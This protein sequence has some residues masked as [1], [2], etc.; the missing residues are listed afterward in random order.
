MPA[1]LVTL[2]AA[3]ACMLFFAPILFGGRPPAGGDGLLQAAP[4]IEAPPHVWQPFSGLG[5]PAYADPNAMLFYPVA[6]LARA[7]PGAFEFFMVAPFFIASCALFALCWRLTRSVA[8]AAT[9]A[10]VFTLGGFLI[11]HFGHYNI[12]HPAAWSIV[13]FAALEEVRA[14]PRARWPCIV[15][16]LA[17]ALCALGGQPQI[18]AFALALGIAYAIAFARSA[19]EGAWHYGRRVA[20]ASGLGLALA[21]V[22]LIPE[23]RLAQAS[24]RRALGIDDLVLYSLPLPELP[25]QLLFPH[26]LDPQ[27]TAIAEFSDYAGVFGLLLALV[28]ATSAPRDGRVR[29]WCLIALLGAALSLGQ[30]LVQLTRHLPLYGL[31]RVPGRHAY[32]TTLALAVLASFGAATI[33]RKRL[34]LRAALGAI[35]GLAL[36]GVGAIWALHDGHS[37]T[38]DAMRAT[39]PHFASIDRSAVFVPVAIGIAG[40]LLVALGRFAPTAMLAFA[41]PA[42]ALLDLSSF[43]WYSYWNTS[44]AAVSPLEPTALARFLAPRLHG[45]R[46]A[47]LPGSAGGDLPPNLNVLWNVPLVENYSSLVLADSAAL[48]GTSGLT[49]RIADVDEAAFDLADVRYVAVPKMPPTELAAS[50]PIGETTLNCYIGPPASGAPAARVRLGYPVPIVADTIA[51]VTSLGNGYAIRDGV[52]VADLIVTFADGTVVRRSVRAGRDTAEFAYD[53]PDIRPIV[54][55]ARAHVFADVGAAGHLYIATIALGHRANVVSAEVRWRPGVGERAAMTV[56]ALSFVDGRSGRAYPVRT[57][58]WELYAEPSHWRP[59]PFD[60]DDVFENRGTL[61]RAWIA[62]R[63]LSA[64]PADAIAAIR[65]ARPFPYRTTAVVDRAPALGAAHAGDAV[66]V[67]PDDTSAERLRVRCA[68]ACLVVES[69]ADYPGWTARIDGRAAPLVTVDGALRGVVV[70]VGEHEVALRFFPWDLVVGAAISTLALLGI[71]S[72]SI[73]PRWSP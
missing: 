14:R 73:R 34:T 12:D 18:L 44:A 70:P 61:G 4:A 13:Y 71:L 45:A 30:P 24:I 49:D 66:S 32:E 68:A 51:L 63:A 1:L 33:V 58:A 21:A 23:A 5:H 53:R 62:S 3:A 27:S 41:V 47:W 37:A 50:A 67:Q 42:L 11:G 7:L 2:V 46:A 17:L 25:V 29:F 22:L 55:H 40:V 38:L 8:A 28:G 65:G 69:A 16:A 48:L 54:A 9:G 26:L 59:V 43:A 10:I 57:V 64:S 20:V 56:H 35:A 72:V 39:D 36:I 31:F 6:I 60:D 19:P 52:S 15:V